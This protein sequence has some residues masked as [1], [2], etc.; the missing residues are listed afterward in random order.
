MTR[1]FGMAAGSQGCASSLALAVHCW[2]CT[3][4]S[5]LSTRLPPPRTGRPRSRPPAGP[6]RSRHNLGRGHTARTAG[7]KWHQLQGGVTRP[8]RRRDAATPNDARRSKTSTSSSS[9][10]K[11]AAFGTPDVGRPPRTRPGGRGKTKPRPRRSCRRRQRGGW[12]RS[13]LEKEADRAT[14]PRVRKQGVAAA[15]ACCLHA[16]HS[17]GQ[18]R[19]L[20][21]SLHP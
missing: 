11:G 3:R 5:G 21:S 17:R 10:S 19:P 16:G 8:A 2:L 14:G 7:K 4:R 20:A 9:K 12:E 15:S 13:E 18:R 1:S 6:H